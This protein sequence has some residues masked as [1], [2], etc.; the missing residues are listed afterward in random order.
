MQDEK[1]PDQSLL[2]EGCIMRMD[3][4]DSVTDVECTNECASKHEACEFEEPKPAIVGI[5]KQVCRRVEQ[6]GSSLGS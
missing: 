2:P 1:K 6:S 5:E 4:D 3:A